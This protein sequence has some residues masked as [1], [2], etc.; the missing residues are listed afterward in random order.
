VADTILLE[1]VTPQR[2]V[3]SEEVE[4][5]R[6]PGI[7]GEMG[8][9]PGH[10]ELLTALGTGAMAFT[11]GGAERRVALQGGFAEVLPTKVTVLATVAEFPGEIDVA[12][13][14]AELGEAEA[15]LP[16]ATAEDL[17]TLTD[18]VRLAATRIDVGGGA[19]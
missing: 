11:T 10:T 8:V 18:Q 15:K 6:L 13:A 4:E 2:L 9:L 5:V 1:L 14:Q 19:N 16:T 12:A 17:E 3:L 7:L